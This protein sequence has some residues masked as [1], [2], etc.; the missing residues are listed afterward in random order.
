MT[1]VLSQTGVGTSAVHVPDTF[2]DPFNI[3][4]GCVVVSG[5]VTYTVEHTFENAM[6]D[7]FDPATAVWFPNSGLT[8]QTTNQ[9][10]N[11]A[12]AVNGIRLNVTGGTGTVKL[13]IVQAGTGQTIIEGP[14]EAPPITGIPWRFNPFYKGSGLGLSDG[15]L[16]LSA[17]QSLPEYRT[18]LGTY[19]IQPTDKV[20]MSLCATSLQGFASSLGFATITANLDF[21]LGVDTSGLGIYSDTRFINNDVTIYQNITPPF[22]QGDI[23]DVCVDAAT[24]NV[25]YRVNGGDWNGDALADP[26]ANVGGLLIPGPSAPFYPAVSILSDLGEIDASWTIQE[27]AAYTAPAGFTFLYGSP[28]QTAGLPWRFDD[29]YVAPSG[30]IVNGGLT[31]T[32]GSNPH[33]TYLGT[34]EIQ[35]SDKVMISLTQTSIPTNTSSYNAAGFSTTG[36]ALSDWI[37]QD[38]FSVGAWSN[39]G[40]Y[41]NGSPIATT[42]DFGV[43]GSI[44]DVCIDASLMKF[45]CRVNNNAW[46]GDPETGAGGSELSPGISAPF[47]PA[48]TLTPISGTSYLTANSSSAFDVPAGFTFLYGEAAPAPA[49][50]PWS[51]DAAHKSLPIVL[52][53]GDLTASSSMTAPPYSQTLVGTQSVGASELVMFSLTFNSTPP[54]S[55]VGYDAFGFGTQSFGPSTNDMGFTTLSVGIYPGDG[56]YYNGSYCGPCEVFSNNG[57][58]VDV[59]FDSSS[60]KIWVRV[61]GGNWNSDTLSDPALNIGGSIVSGPALPVY[62][63]LAIYVSDPGDP[64]RTWTINSTAVHGVPNGFT[65]LYGEAP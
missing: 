46:D 60:M 10:G 47:R 1:V 20:M 35:S 61:N 53:N 3:G 40:V 8:S 32:S 14:I 26:A 62:P 55:G 54:N 27:T 39:D 64:V 45:W 6:A 65:F 12:Y 41:Y 28:P 34:R 57:D 4:L 7:D 31:V 50:V 17:F 9:Q 43:Y 49:P 23:I 2:L 24:M 5:S 58:I 37:G 11:Y 19:L 16:T 22:S 29:N 21:Y 52:S 42:P 48:V 18:A 33:S 44:V 56:I 59:C 51:W 30:S 13:Y 25:W 36:I 15:N 63:A 38:T